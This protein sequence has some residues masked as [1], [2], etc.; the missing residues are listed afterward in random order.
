VQ[1]DCKVKIDAPHGPE[2]LFDPLSP[3]GS[4]RWSNPGSEVTS[5]TVVPAEGNPE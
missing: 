5:R 4:G 3:E 2:S 1:R